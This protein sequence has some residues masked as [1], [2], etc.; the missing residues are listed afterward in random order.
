MHDIADRF[1]RPSHICRVEPGSQACGFPVQRVRVLGCHGVAGHSQGLR[2]VMGDAHGK[3][4][5]AAFEV[6]TQRAPPR[7]RLGRAP[8]RPAGKFDSRRIEM[9][10]HIVRIDWRNF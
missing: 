1:E 5:R 3:P 7:R 6:E 4:D 2:A 10:Y 8:D 9:S